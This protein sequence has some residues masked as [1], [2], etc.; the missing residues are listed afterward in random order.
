MKRIVLTLLVLAFWTSTASAYTFSISNGTTFESVNPLVSAETGADYYGY[1]YPSGTPAF[2]PEKGTAF[3]WL[4]E[5]SLTGEITLGMIFNATGAG[6]F[7]GNMTL[8]LSG[9]PSGWSWSVQDDTNEVGSDGTTPSWLWLSQYTDGG[10]IAG[11]DEEWE[12]VIQLLSVAGIDNW[13]FLSGP[14][15]TNPTMISLN[16]DG[17]D[18][19]IQSQTSAVPLPAAV[20]LFGSGILGLIGFSKRKQ[21]TISRV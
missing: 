7:G 20:W 17:Q 8:S 12:I 21:T 18:L 4:H 1:S 5:N 13:Y 6:G 9:L 11:L 2:G 16:L 19:I 14:D 10:V 3:F 15:G